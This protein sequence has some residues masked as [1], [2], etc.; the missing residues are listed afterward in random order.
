MVSF[1]SLSF[2][3]FWRKLNHVRRVLLLMCGIRNQYNCLQLVY[4]SYL[5]Q[6][7]V[8]LAMFHTLIGMV[9]VSTLHECMSYARIV[10]L[11]ASCS[12]YLVHKHRIFGGMLLIQ[13]Y[14]APFVC[15][16]VDGRYSFCV[17]LLMS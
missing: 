17:L 13:Y 2:L 15:L 4:L 7:E 10:L 11:V 3:S 8:Q 5:R 6:G 9:I 16:F 14:I 12:M 1:F